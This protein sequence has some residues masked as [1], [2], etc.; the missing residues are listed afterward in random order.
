MRLLALAVVLALASGCRTPVTAKAKTAEAEKDVYVDKE[1]N[2]H[3]FPS[4]TDVP[5][6]ATNLGTVRVAKVQGSSDEEMYLLLREA[7]CKAGGDALS[8]LR[9]VKEL[10]KISGKPTELEAT[11]W[12]L[13]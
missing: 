11:A 1:C 12:T 2:V 8:G 13:P 6:G 7:I 9:W 4:I 10:G 5:E 3:D